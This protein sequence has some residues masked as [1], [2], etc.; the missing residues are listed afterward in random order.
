MSNNKVKFNLKNVHAAP[1]TFAGSTPVFGTPVAIPGAVAITLSIKGEPENFYADGGVYYVIANNQGYDG[2]LELAL[3]PEFFRIAY[4]GESLDSNNVLVE[5]S[6]AELKPFALMFEF[7][8]D[9]KHIRHVLYNCTAGR[10]AVEGKTNEDKRSVQTEKLNIKAAPLPN[11][12]VKVRTGDNTDA[13]VYENWYN[14]VYTPNASASVA[15]LSA[16]TITGVTLTP[17]FS[18]YEFAYAAVT[19][20]SSNAVTATGDTGTSVQLLVNGESHTSGSAA[21]WNTGINTIVAIVTK[22]GCESRTY[23]VNVTKNAA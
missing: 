12:L 16:L 10:T 5:R 18:P 8:G 6:D 22:S 17:A 13:A 1:L 23:T 14:S 4:L 11:G 2:D 20:D 21:T 19:S 9:Q 3:V 15:R 7:D